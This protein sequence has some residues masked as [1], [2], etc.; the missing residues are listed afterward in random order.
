[1]NQKQPRI[2]KAHTKSTEKMQKMNLSYKCLTR[3]RK[4]TLHHLPELTFSPTDL[5]LFEPKYKPKHFKKQKTLAN[6]CA[7]MNDDNVPSDDY[8]IVDKKIPH[9]QNYSVSNLNH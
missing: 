4:K 3:A 7:L 5:I 2:L 1:M 6:V 8:D 9:N